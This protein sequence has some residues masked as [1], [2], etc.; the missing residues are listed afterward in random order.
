MGKIAFVFSGQGAQYTGM[1]KELYDCSP[2]AKKVFDISDCKIARDGDKE[3]VYLNNDDVSKKFNVCIHSVVKLNTIL[4][5]KYN[6]NAKSLTINNEPDMVTYLGYDNIMTDNCV[7]ENK[8]FLNELFNVAYTNSDFLNRC[9]VKRVEQSGETFDELDLYLK[10]LS[11][12]KENVLR[13][14]RTFH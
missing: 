9:N 3:K 5:P 7:I 2:A 11:G 14:T 13:F 8:R 12:E 10:K 6:A 1:G 4:L